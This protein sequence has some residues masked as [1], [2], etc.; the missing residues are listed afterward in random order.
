MKV[1]AGVLEKNPCQ[2]KNRSAEFGMQGKSCID[3][4]VK[5][6]DVEQIVEAD[7]IL[8]WRYIFVVTHR[9]ECGWQQYL[10]QRIRVEPSKVNAA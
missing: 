1:S 2:L 8:L 5:N 10:M 7:T 3:D 4:L 9:K 6:T